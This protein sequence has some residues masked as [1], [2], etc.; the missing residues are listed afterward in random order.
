[1]SGKDILIIGWAFIVIGWC[2]AIIYIL[3]ILNKI[4]AILS[5]AKY[6]YNTVMWFLFKPV[7][8]VQNLISKISK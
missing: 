6:R 4:N 7:E 2:I 3:V 5:D 8:L 1:M